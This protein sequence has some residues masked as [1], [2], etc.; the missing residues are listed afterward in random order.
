MIHPR[1]PTPKAAAATVAVSTEAPA[2]GSVAGTADR[3]VPAHLLLS[4]HSVK[5]PIHTIVDHYMETKMDRTQAVVT[6][7]SEY[8][9]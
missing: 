7:T 3:Q 9:L 1:V 8:K 6:P 4:S 5:S 2:G